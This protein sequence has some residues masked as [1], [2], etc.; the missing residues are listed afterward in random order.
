MFSVRLMKATPLRSKGRH[1]LQEVAQRP[2]Q[3][4]QP[5]DHHRV[6]GPDLLEEVVEGRSGLQLPAGL[7]HEDPLTAGGHQRIVLE[8]RILLVGRH[9]G[10]AQP[11]ASSRGC[12]THRSTST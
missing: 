3:P 5:P 6:P 12:R 10:I 7:V 9:P 1:R 11:I 8:G 2:P 4:V